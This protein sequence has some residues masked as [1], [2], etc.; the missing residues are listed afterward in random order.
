[1]ILPERNRP[2]LDDVP[3]DVRDAMH[4]HPV[5]SLGEVLDI[6]LEPAGHGLAAVS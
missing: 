1:V 4:F 5:M 6:A 3:A 2:D